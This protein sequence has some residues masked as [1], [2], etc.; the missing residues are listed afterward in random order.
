MVVIAFPQER[1]DP[2]VVDEFTAVIAEG[3]V[4]IVDLL[5]VRKD[6][7]GEVTVDEFDVDA[8]EGDDLGERLDLVSGEDV[9]A[10]GEGLEP[11]R[12]ALRSSSSS[13]RG[14]SPLRTPSAP[15]V[16]WSPSACPSPMTSPRQLQQLSVRDV[17]SRREHPCHPVEEDE[18]DPDWSAPWHGRPSSSAR[19]RPSTAP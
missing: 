13:T 10:I 19:P 3:A 8:D 17:W 1:V 5:V 6:T 15:P 7:A 12:L 18:E 9:E 16:A 2:K 11:E 14:R 4:T